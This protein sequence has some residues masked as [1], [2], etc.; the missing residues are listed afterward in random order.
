ML[1]VGVG[2]SPPNCQA[3][4]SRADWRRIETVRASDRPSALA[5]PT[6]FKPDQHR[7]SHCTG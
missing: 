1:R 7:M 4:E 5:Y 3:A 2:S 6:N